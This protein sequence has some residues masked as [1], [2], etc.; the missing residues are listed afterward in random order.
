MAV[1]A[2]DGC[3]CIDFMQG[4]TLLRAG[5]CHELVVDSMKNKQVRVCDKCRILQFGNIIIF[6]HAIKRTWNLQFLNV[7]GVQIVQIA[8]A[9]CKSTRIANT[10]QKLQSFKYSHTPSLFPCLPHLSPLILLLFAREMQHSNQRTCWSL[11][12]SWCNIVVLCC[13]E[14]IRISLHCMFV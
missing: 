11:Y 12:S 4:L 13:A 5:F 7:Q 3:Q 10:V 2:F 6:S 1:A 9:S 14:T 8:R